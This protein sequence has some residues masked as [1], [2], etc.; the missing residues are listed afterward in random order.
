MKLEQTRDIIDW[1]VRFHDSLGHQYESISE[2]TAEPRLKMMLDY[3]AQHEHEMHAGLARFLETASPAVLNTWFRQVPELPQPDAL[4]AL[5][6]CLCCASVDDAE[7]AARAF[8]TELQG[9]YQQLAD[10]SETAQLRE[11]FESLVNGEDAELRR[12]VRDT[13]QLDSL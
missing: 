10:V 8:H 7:N 5:R 2:S 1:C 12:M 4:E 11:L 9:M 6:S 13:A 3:L